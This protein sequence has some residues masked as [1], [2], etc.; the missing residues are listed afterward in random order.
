MAHDITHVLLILDP[1]S[2]E[3]LRAAGYDRLPTPEDRVALE[4]AWGC[5]CE[6]VDADKEYVDSMQ[7][8]WRQYRDTGG[9]R[10]EN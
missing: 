2:K 5:S 3:V 6:I 10:L 8:I 4:E 9:M 7:W 1:K